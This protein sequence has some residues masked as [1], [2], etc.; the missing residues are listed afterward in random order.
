[1]SISLYLCKNDISGFVK[2]NIAKFIVIIILTVLAV[3]LAIRN[4][5]LIDSVSDFYEN[6]V[7]TLY[8]YLCG[9][10]T[11]F[12]F[13]L[14]SLLEY[15]ILLVFIM[16]SAYNDWTVILAFVVPVYKSYIGI[17]N[18]VVVLRYFS[19]KA[20]PFAILYTLLTFALLCV[21]ASYIIFIIS[22]QTRYKYSIKEL[23]C[24]AAQSLP[25]YFVFL[26]LYFL[27]ILFVCIGAV[28]I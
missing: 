27:Q 3:I 13:M 20:L 1:M 10:G 16:L 15:S 28:F 4:A 23:Y 6:S 7:S 14:V 8:G 9:E 2:K 12:A 26:V 24:L 11:L 19:I 18:M 25:F 21:Y 17:F 22:S 5:V